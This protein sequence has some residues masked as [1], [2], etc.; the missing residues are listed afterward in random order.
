MRSINVMLAC[1]AIHVNGAVVDGFSS[2]RFPRE[3]T[4]E[5]AERHFVHPEAGAAP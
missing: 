3:Q 5:E 4:P 1:I 2:M